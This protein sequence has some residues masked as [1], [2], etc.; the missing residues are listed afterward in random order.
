MSPTVCWWGR[1]PGLR[2]KQQ[3]PHWGSGCRPGMM[4]AGRPHHSQAPGWWTKG[5]SPTPGRWSTGVAV[6]LV[7][8][9]CG[10]RGGGRG[11]AAL[12]VSGSWGIAWDACALQKGVA[13][14][15]HLG[16]VAT[17]GSR[18]TCAL[19]GS[20]SRVTTPATMDTVCVRVLS[21]GWRACPQPKK[22]FSLFFFRFFLS[23]FA[24]ECAASISW[25]PHSRSLPPPL[26]PTPCH[27]SLAPKKR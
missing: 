11:A 7:Q 13:G 21:R 23:A 22:H 26:V 17:P 16:P 10:G 8:L 6:P 19:G 3:G 5:Q 4:V 12:G 1:R 24:A 25:V 2:A 27:V 18:R 14:G 20:P 15:T 9:Q